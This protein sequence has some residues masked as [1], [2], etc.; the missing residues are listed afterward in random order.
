[1]NHRKERNEYRR[2][3]NILNKERISEL[4]K[5]RYQKDIISLRKA[6]RVRDRKYYQSNKNRKFSYHYDRIAT[7]DSY[8]FRVRLR[9]RLYKFLKLKGF[10]KQCKFND[11]VG[12]TLENLKIHIEKRFSKGMNWLNYGEWHIDHIVP[13][14][15]AKTEKEIYKLFH[16]S[17]LQPLW[18]ID[19]IRKGSKIII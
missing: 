17:N 19:N 11:Y 5:I 15:S 6:S 8:R 1:M 2:K 4:R 7:D 12:C 3:Y 13:L 14:A 10:Q 18:G 16:Y 9:N